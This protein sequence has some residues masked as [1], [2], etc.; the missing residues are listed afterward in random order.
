[1][2]WAGFLYGDTNLW[3]LEVTL[4]IIGW[5]RLKMSETFGVF[6][7]WFDELSWLIEWF[8]HAN[9]DGIIFGLMA[10]IFC[11][12]DI[13]MLYG[14]LLARVFERNSLWEKWHE[15]MFFSLFCKNFSLIFAGNILK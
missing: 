2:K 9:G 10:N 6:H 3:K 4:I 7:I 11:I 14:Q 13:Q 1:M 8:L 12:F 5:K 15:N